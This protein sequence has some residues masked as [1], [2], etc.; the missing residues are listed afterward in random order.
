MFGI[1]FGYKPNVSSDFVNFVIVRPNSKNISI[2]VHQE[3]SLW[4]L[5]EISYYT[6]YPD[7][8]RNKFQPK[9]TL[10]FSGKPTTSKMNKFVHDN[11]PT[12]NNNDNH[13]IYDIFVSNNEMD[14][15]KSIPVTKFIKISDFIKNSPEY[16]NNKKKIYKLFIVDDKI[17]RENL[18]LEKKESTISEFTT[19]ISNKLSAVYRGKP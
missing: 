8:D 14:D 1:N 13:V 4:D 15:I 18:F 5:Y 3:H 11:I 7:A 16:F 2:T 9:T 6:L 17:L 10:T 19:Y 12:S